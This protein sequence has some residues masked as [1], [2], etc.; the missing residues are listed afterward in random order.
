LL[1]FQHTEA[2]QVAKFPLIREKVFSASKIDIPTRERM[3]LGVLFS[4]TGKEE[5]GI[6]IERVDRQCY[7]ELLFAAIRQVQN[8][9]STLRILEK[10]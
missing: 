7:V 6:V 3:L 5:L 9:P 8:P 10:K 1:C 2:A 4:T